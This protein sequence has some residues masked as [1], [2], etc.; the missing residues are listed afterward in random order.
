[1]TLSI[2]IPLGLLIVIIGTILYFVL[3]NKMI[4][5]LII[6]IGAIV[7]LVTLIMV[8]MAVFSNM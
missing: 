6:W 7:T 5:K 1:M 2:G 8:L 3:K 4:A